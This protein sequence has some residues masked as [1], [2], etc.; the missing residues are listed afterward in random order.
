MEILPPSFDDSGRTKYPVLFR[1][2]GGPD[3]Q[4]V[5][6]RFERDWHTYLACSLKYIIV[7]VDG[8]GTGFKGRKLENPVRGNLGYWETKD[9]IEAARFVSFLFHNVRIKMDFAIGYGRRNRM[10]ILSA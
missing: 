5:H 6:T 1:V 3:S 4:M 7:S 2:Y 8:R 9:Q 10:S